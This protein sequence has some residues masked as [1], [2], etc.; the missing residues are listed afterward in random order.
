MVYVLDASRSVPVV[1]SMVDKNLKQRQEYCEDIAEQYAEM[2]DEFYA[3]LED[4]KY[5]TLAQA[6]KKAL[7]VRRGEWGCVSR[8]PCLAVS[9][10]LWPPC[11][12]T[13]ARWTGLIPPTSP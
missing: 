12:T 6:Q 4:R 10:D 5:L 3:G 9:P 8:P 2:R 7:K 1:Q 11:L 13:A